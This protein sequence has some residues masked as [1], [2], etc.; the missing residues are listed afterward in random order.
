MTHYRPCR[1]VELCLSKNEVSYIYI[2]S[3]EIPRRTQGDAGGLVE[4]T[5]AAIR[6]NITLVAVALGRL[7]SGS[8]ITPR[9]ASSPGPR[10]SAVTTPLAARNSAKNSSR[11]SNF[12]P[13]STL[14]LPSQQLDTLSADLKSQRRAETVNRADTEFLVPGPCSDK[15]LLTNTCFSCPPKDFLEKQPFTY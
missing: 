1:C 5:R 2:S 10:P 7:F 11:G 4:R 15:R 8:P 14:Y 6:H 13:S 12:A 3:T 9:A